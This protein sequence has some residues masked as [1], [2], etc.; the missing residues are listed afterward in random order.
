MIYPGFIYFKF[1]V[2]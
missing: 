2:Y 1:F